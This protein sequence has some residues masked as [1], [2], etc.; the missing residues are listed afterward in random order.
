MSDTQTGARLIRS[1]RK[2]AGLTQTTLARRAGEPQSVVSAYE[3]GRR[4]PSASALNRLIEAAGFRLVIVPS[5]RTAPDARRSAEVFA[6]A[7]GLA[8]DLPRR[9][10][11]PH[12]AYPRLPA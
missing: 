4:Q 5:P 7:L 9:R 6:E 3:R 11:P 1:A 12:L 10:R 2:S 8:E